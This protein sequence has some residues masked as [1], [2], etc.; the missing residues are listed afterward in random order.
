VKANYIKLVHIFLLTIIQSLASQTYERLI[1]TE[2]D[3]IAYDAVSLNDSTIIIISQHGYYIAHEYQQ[4]KIYSINNYGLFKDSLTI[5]F[6]EFYPIRFAQNIFI[7]KNHNLVIAGR[8][9][10]KLCSTYMQYIAVIDDNLNLLLDTITG[11][12]QLS[13]VGTYYIINNKNNLI[14]VGFTEYNLTHKIYISEYSLQGTLLKRAEFDWD[15][16]SASSVIEIDEKSAYYLTTIYGSTGGI[17]VIDSTTFSIIDTLTFSPSFQCF[18]TKNNPSGQ[19]YY[20]A[21]NVLQSGVWK[22]FLLNIDYDGQILNE[23]TY[24]SLD[25]NSY[26]SLNS[27]DISTLNKIFIVGTHNFPNQ[28]PFFSTEPRWILANKLN[29]DGSIVW[30]RFYKG[31]LSYMPYKVLAT[32]DGGAL[33]LSTKYD[34]NDPFPNQRDVH[35]L[36]IDSTGYYDPITSTP[37]EKEQMNKQILVYPNPAEKEVNFVLGL[38]SNLQLF[39]YNSIGEL[40][41]TEL[42]PASKTIDISSLPGGVYLYLLNGKNG[43][44]ETGKILKK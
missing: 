27:M 36:K 25:T 37:E 1:R 35:I 6:D 33:I 38:Y 39:V 7:D 18:D 30:Q 10:N 2:L 8:V 44:K 31:E 22:L 19:N 12:D 32:N 34:W 20:M 23:S 17:P 28:P 41:L 11:N 42:L 43:F 29:P 24:G 16:Y 13:D 9:I 5:L 4:I 15:A 14:A 40:K 3:D 21:G 26:Y